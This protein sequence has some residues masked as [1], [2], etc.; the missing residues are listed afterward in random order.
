VTEKTQLPTFEQLH[1]HGSHGKNAQAWLAAN[2][3]VISLAR[4]YGLSYTKNRRFLSRLALEICEP[5]MIL[6]GEIP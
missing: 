2:E 6:T 1:K 4:Q 5:G 3:R